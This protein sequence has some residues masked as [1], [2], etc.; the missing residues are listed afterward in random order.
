[1]K[2][3]KINEFGNLDNLSKTPLNEAFSN[4]D[5]KAA[6]ILVNVDDTVDNK[7]PYEPKHNLTVE[8][9]DKVLNLQRSSFIKD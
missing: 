6:N 1:M 2:S 4:L 7:S 5:Y 9:D 3:S 8:S